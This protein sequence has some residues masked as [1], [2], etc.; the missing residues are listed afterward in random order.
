M[1]QKIFINMFRNKKSGVLT[2]GLWLLMNRIIKNST[3][4]H[5]HTDAINLVRIY[6]VQF[7]SAKLWLKCESLTNNSKNVSIIINIRAK[8]FTLFFMLW[9][10]VWGVWLGKNI[11]KQYTSLLRGP[12]CSYKMTNCHQ[13]GWHVPTLRNPTPSGS[14]LKAKNTSRIWI[15]IW[16]HP[17]RLHLHASTSHWKRK[18]KPHPSL[19]T[20]LISRRGVVL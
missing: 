12:R 10:D 2:K 4:T 14:S 3:N 8:C 13:W 17:H 19:M 15:S 6:N 9:A 20:A 1:G 11:N 18:R 7:L 5:R 16:Y